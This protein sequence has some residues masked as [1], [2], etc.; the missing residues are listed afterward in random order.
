MAVIVNTLLTV[1]MVAILMEKKVGWAMDRTSHQARISL[2]EEEVRTKA[3]MPVLT[4]M[5]VT[6]DMALPVVPVSVQ[7]VEVATGVVV[8]PTQLQV[9]EDPASLRKVT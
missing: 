6:L 5:L 1:E 8:E 2:E 4:V 9:G 7:V 3:A